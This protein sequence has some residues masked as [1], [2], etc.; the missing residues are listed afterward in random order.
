MTFRGRQVHLS[1]PDRRP[2]LYVYAI[3][4]SDFDRQ[5]PATIEPRVAVNHWANVYAEEPL[6]L[7]PHGYIELT[8][9]ERKDFKREMEFNCTVEEEE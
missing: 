3:R 9:E 5:L 1:P 2:A 8:K 6:D 4:H 7:G